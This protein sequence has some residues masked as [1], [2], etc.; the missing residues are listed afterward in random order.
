MLKTIVFLMGLW[1]LLPG[2]PTQPATPDCDCPPI[3]NLQKTG[4]TSSSISFTWEGPDA[5]TGYKVWYVRGQSASG[6]SYPSGTSWEFA[7]LPPGEY[8]FYFTAVCGGSESSF[9]GIEDII[10]Y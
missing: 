10:E 1:P 9:I 2:F 3:A 8:T 5:A 7:G 6:Y 4:E